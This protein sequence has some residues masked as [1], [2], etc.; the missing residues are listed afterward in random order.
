MHFSPKFWKRRHLKPTIT[1]KMGFLI[2]LAAIQALISLGGFYL[3]L[4]R[5]AF[6]AYLINIAGRQRMLSQQLLVYANMVRIGQ[7][8]DRDLLQETVTQFEQ[9]LQALVNGGQLL[10]YPIPPVPQEVVPKLSQMQLIWSSLKAPLLTVATSPPG[11]QRMGMAFMQVMQNIGPLT[12]AAD[13]LVSALVQR[14]RALRHATLHTLAATAI[15]SLLLFLFGV[16]YIRRYITRP[17]LL[18]EEAVRHVKAGD[19]SRRVPV[20]TNDELA[21]LAQTF[22]EMSGNLEQLLTER[23]QSQAQLLYSATHDQLTDLLNRNSFREAV[24]RAVDQALRY[25]QKGAVMFI[26]LDNFKYFNDSMGHQAGDELLRKVADALRQSLRDKDTLARLGG[27]EFAALLPDINEAQATS[28]AERI[29][30][31][32]RKNKVIAGDHPVDVTASIGIALFPDHGTTAD[33]LL[34]NADMAMYKAKE[35]G[36]SR[37]CLWDSGLEQ[38]ARMHSDMTWSGRIRQAL[39]EG[40]FV[41]HLQ[42]ILDLHTDRISQYEALIRMVGE[43]GELIPPGEFI[44][45]AERFGL[46]QDIDRWATK[47][48]I[49]L[50]GDCQKLG[51][52]LRLEVNLSAKAL[53]DPDFIAI[54]R[55][56]LAET[57]VNP[58]NLVFE[59]TETAAISNMLE[60]ERFINA[61][62]TLGCRF[63]LDD[64]G[65][66]FSSFNH[67]KHLPVDYLKIDGSFIRDLPRNPVDQH[68]VRAMVQIAKGL[69]KKTIAEFVTDRETLALVRELGVDYAQGYCVS[70]PCAVHAALLAENETNPFDQCTFP[71]CIMT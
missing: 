42:G 3:Y 36:R 20:I 54:V 13:S 14:N 56:E 19:F 46:I 38:T 1:K 45:V 71:N 41:L 60:A 12:Q 2:L 30:E 52:E 67:L 70:R 34:V 35:N 68:I 44:P 10:G 6:D 28:V 29:L 49:R 9:A 11:D 43:S 51:R 15:L 39:D 55:K 61:L 22:N 21:A 23:E 26:D 25:R 64:F 18:L 27:D 16:W 8:E 37:F 57:G 24:S 63:A 48:A 65:V 66:G 17:I 58:F 50:A 62:K 59:I 47:Q 31:T 32:L 69:G 4:D 5:T 33:E 53:I 7:E 40:R